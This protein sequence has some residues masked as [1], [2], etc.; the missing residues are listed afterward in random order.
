MKN[1]AEEL[2]KLGGARVIIATAPDS[3]AM[4]EQLA[5]SY[6]GISDTFVLWRQVPACGII[7]S[8]H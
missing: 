3:K 5:S 1:A 7:A 4:T 8:T 6:Q 2:Q